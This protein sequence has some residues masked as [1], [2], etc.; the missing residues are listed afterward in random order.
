MRQILAGIALSALLL[1]GCNRLRNQEPAS[2]SAAAQSTAAGAQRAANSGAAQGA[3]APMPGLPGAGHPESAAVQTLVIPAGTRIHV[4][5]NQRLDTRHNRAG[6]QFQ[7]TLRTPVVVGGHVVVPEGTPFVGRVVHVKPSGRLRGRAV[8]ELA[9]QSFE[10]R[11]A[12]YRIATKVSYRASS[13]HKRRN[14]ALIGGGS[15]FGAA[16]GAVAGGGA[17]ALIGAGA[18][19]AAGTTG[20][21]ITGRKNVRLAAETPLVF[22]LRRDVSL[23]S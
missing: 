1:A 17:G 18:G 15:G 3:L 11:G 4:R 14:L 8:L 16:V 12:T 9:L 20:A 6:D 7:A 21:L 13:T 10:L 5:L 2:A 23:T 19:A 22:S